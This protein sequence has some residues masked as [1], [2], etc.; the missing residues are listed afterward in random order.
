M[1]KIKKSEPVSRSDLVVTL[2]TAN[3]RIAELESAL[4]P[5]AKALLEGPVS[6]TQAEKLAILVAMKP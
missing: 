2:T 5:V 6:L 4:A 1:N 3:A